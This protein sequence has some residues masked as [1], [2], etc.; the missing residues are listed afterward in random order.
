M[1]EDFQ[2]F[3]KISENFR[4]VSNFEEMTYCIS[5][6][7]DFFLI[8]KTLKGMCL[9]FTTSQKRILKKLESIKSSTFAEN[10]FPPT[11]SVLGIGRR[12]LS[13]YSTKNYYSEKVE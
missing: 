3:P 4:N 2:E 9:I 5:E 7:S 13:H 1:E 10:I 11:L 12:L 6:L 8:S